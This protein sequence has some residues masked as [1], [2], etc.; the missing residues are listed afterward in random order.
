[1]LEFAT[2]PVVEPPNKYVAD[3]NNQRHGVILPEDQKKTLLDA[4]NVGKKTMESKK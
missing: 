1:M 4:V 2:K 3:K